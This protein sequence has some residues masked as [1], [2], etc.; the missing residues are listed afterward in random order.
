MTSTGE[1]SRAY[2]GVGWKFP[3][4]VTPRGRIALARHELRV[5]ESI[6]LILATATDEG[7]Q[8]A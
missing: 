2:L 6:F 7:E 3:L 1:V 5:E 4:Q 8:D